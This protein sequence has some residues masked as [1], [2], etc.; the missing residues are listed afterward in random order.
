MH[1][2]VKP[3]NILIDLDGNIKLCDFG[4]AGKIIDSNASDGCVAYFS[5][6]RM[7]CAQY[8]ERADIWSLGITLVELAT[9]EFPYPYHSYIELFCAV[10]E[11]PAPSLP[12]Q[13][14][15]EPPEFE[16]FTPEFR[17]FVDK[18]LIKNVE[19]RPKYEELMV[20]F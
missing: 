15:L 12:E 13:F 9:L 6:E 4:I 7:K 14:L 11:M 19:S 18:C 2:D 17:K 8:D 5:P 16:P 1:R 10:T 3:S 20:G